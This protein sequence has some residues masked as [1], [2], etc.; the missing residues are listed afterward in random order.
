VAALAALVA[1]LLARYSGDRRKD[2]PFA[3]CAPGIGL[4]LAGWLS[5]PWAGAER[6]ST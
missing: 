2:K 3:R 4:S 1:A 6:S 5:A